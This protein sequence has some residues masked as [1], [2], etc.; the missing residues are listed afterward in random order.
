MFSCALLFSVLVLFMI[1]V[2]SCKLQRRFA[3][4]PRVEQFLLIFPT[5]KRA[6]AVPWKPLIFAWPHVFA[7]L[8]IRSRGVKQLTNVDPLI[9]EPTS[10]N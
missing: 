10:F 7:L 1:L 3:T 6:A 8:S 2:G 9:N 5:K 4:I